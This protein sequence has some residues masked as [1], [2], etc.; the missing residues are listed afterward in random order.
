MKPQT[1]KVFLKKGVNE[2]NLLIIIRLFLKKKD[3]E[4]KSVAVIVVEMNVF[5][6]TTNVFLTPDN[7]FTNPKNVSAVPENIFALPKKVF[8]IPE[9]VFTSPKKY[10]PVPENILTRPEKVSSVPENNYSANRRD[11]FTQK[12]QENKAEK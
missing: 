11:L 10:S 2:L 7:I 5:L 9:N 3:G 1:R 8:T 6:G 4:G 12:K